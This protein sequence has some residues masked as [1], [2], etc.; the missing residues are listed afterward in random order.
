MRLIL[1]VKW[2]CE[3]LHFYIVILDKSFF[4]GSSFLKDTR[5]RQDSENG[6]Q[7]N[8]EVTLDFFLLLLKY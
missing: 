1:Y 8:G 6:S 5:K 3:M 4:P 2:Y 7:L